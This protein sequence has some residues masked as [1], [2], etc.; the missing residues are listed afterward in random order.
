LVTSI[1]VPRA[2]LATIASDETLWTAL[3][4]MDD[5]GVNQ[6]PVTDG[7]QLIGIL[8]REQLLRVI[9]NQLDLG[10]K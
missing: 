2:R 8:T 1:M 6:L 3:R 10:S 9:R 5:A 7:D 4:R